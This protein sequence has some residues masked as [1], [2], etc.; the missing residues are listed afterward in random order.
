MNITDQINAAQE[1]QHTI[2]TIGWKR[3]E[4]YIDDEIRGHSEEFL[5]LHADEHYLPE[6]SKIQGGWRQLIDFKEWVSR[7]IQTGRR[8]EIAEANKP[9]PARAG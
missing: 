6:I 9:Q 4:K 2:N 1:L 3:I 8:I 5:R 7:T